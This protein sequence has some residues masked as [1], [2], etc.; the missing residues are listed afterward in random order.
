MEIY[1]VAFPLEYD[2]LA[3]QIGAI[4]VEKHQTISWTIRDI[5]CES[6]NFTPVLDRKIIKR[7][8]YP[9]KKRAKKA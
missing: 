4:A 1:T 3:K 8:K 5:L 7:D 9:S 2:D 6:L